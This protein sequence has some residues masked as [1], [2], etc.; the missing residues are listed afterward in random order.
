MR[1]LVMI[2]ILLL[3]VTGCSDQPQ[4]D[5][6]Q[7]QELIQALLY[8]HEFK[9]SSI[10]DE[11]IKTGSI[12]Q[13]IPTERVA[14]TANFWTPLSYAA[15][16]GNVAAVK[17]FIEKGANIHYTDANDQTPL[18]L[19]AISGNMEVIEILLQAGANI[20][21]MDINNR[22][23]LVHAATAGNL[24]TVKYLIEKGCDPTTPHAKQ[25]A[26][27]FALFYQHTEIVDY[28]KSKGLTPHS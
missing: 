4:V 7:E 12:D 26:L 17:L 22:T 21:A 3:T 27:D 23:A 9:V 11:L 24:L 1:Q 28:L 20:N 19:A 14:R 2:M 5:N 25:N 8:R 6:K 16:I 13:K 10:V 15:F 18:I